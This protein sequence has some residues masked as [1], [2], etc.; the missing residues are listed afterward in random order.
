MRLLGWILIHAI[1]V[2]GRR[3]DVNTQD[4]Q[5]SAMLQLSEDWSD[6]ST[7]QGTPGAVRSQERG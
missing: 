1:G 4:T 7:D 6:V 3:K 2:L 5:E